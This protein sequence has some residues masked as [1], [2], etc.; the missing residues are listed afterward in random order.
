MKLI[1]IIIALLPIYL[2]IASV[3]CLVMLLVG[4]S[5]YTPD[6]PTNTVAQISASPEV[7]GISTINYE[8]VKSVSALSTLL[9]RGKTLTPKHTR[10]FTASSETLFVTYERIRIKTQFVPLGF[11]M[12]YRISSISAANG[13]TLFAAKPDLVD[14]LMNSLGTADTLTIPILARPRATSY[15]VT[16]SNQGMQQYEN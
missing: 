12:L 4:L 5:R 9:T 16:I 1:R 7:L 3:V 14:S 6:L 13:D 2:F 8:E 15:T 10:T 11:T